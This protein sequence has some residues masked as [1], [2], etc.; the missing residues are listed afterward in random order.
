MTNKKIIEKIEEGIKDSI[1]RCKRS[2]KEG[3]MTKR[4]IENQIIGLR[5]AL[6]RVKLVK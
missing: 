4:D 3:K 6:I 2:A 1:Y 5:E